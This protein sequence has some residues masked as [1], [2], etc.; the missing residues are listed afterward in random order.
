MQS[1]TGVPNFPGAVWL[2]TL[3]YGLTPDPLVATLF[4]GLIGVVGVWGIWWLSRQVWDGWTS[5]G[6]AL[7]LTAAPFIVFYSRSIWSQNLLPPLAILWAVTA[8]H[9]ISRG[10]GRTLALHAFLSGFVGQVHLAGI[11]LALGSLW[12]GLFFRLWRHWKP[13]TVGIVA[14]VMSAMPTIYTIAKYGDGAQSDI[15]TILAQPSQTY[16]DNFT[17]L[18]N[19]AI[20]RDWEPFWLNGSWVWSAPLDTLLS[21][22]ISL[23]SVLLLTGVIFYGYRTSRLAKTMWQ[24][25]QN[26][27]L[28]PRP[29][30]VLVALLPVWAV[31]SPLFFY[32]SRTDVFIQ[33]MLASAPPLFLL[34]GAG[35]GWLS[36]RWLSIGFGVLCFGVAVV[37]TAAI[38]ETLNTIGE[39]QVEGGMGTP[40][41]YPRAAMEELKADGREILIHSIG[42]TPEFDG[43]AAVFDVLLWGYPH[44]L[45]DGR[46]ALIIPREPA[47]LFATFDT[48][49]AWH[50][51]P[52][53]VTNREPLARRSNEPPYMV[54]HTDGQPD[55]DDSWETA[56][57]SLQNGATLIGWR[58][59]G[60]ED[61]RVRLETVWQLG[62]ELGAGQIQQ[63][64][65][66]YSTADPDQPT[67]V[68]DAS[69]SSNAWRAG[70]RLY[71]WAEFW[72]LPEG[73]ELVRFDVGM[74]TWPDLQ[75]SPVLD[76]EGDP[77]API[78]LVP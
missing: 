43:D 57:V 36:R 71:T 38:V 66:L 5:M 29:E 51:L 63:F 72:P 28:L 27:E 19:L 50:A 16:P 45:V 24:T 17:Y 25:V 35:I 68:S 23:L 39:V 15:G 6:V 14:G 60:L 32:Q 67:H 10:D 26:N 7:L 18:L 40:L 55:L 13:V 8:V 3:P 53:T 11:A 33:Y 61:G 65:H 46:S 77:L 62:D 20:G 22:I 34:M 78:Q 31:C 70:D 74:Y 1:S 4:A 41:S 2:F 12:L 21:A 44:R 64:N 9:G 59:F 58:Y 56:D 48:V 73:A 47:H 75:R 69:T 52:E 54:A 37:H 42:N 49:P 76:R 30:H